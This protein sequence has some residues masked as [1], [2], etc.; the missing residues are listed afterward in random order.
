MK[1][2]KRIQQLELKAMNKYLDGVEWDFVIQALHD[3]EQEE[4]KKLIKE[5]Y[6]D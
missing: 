4:Y 3:E 1:K 5:V 2:D 6:G